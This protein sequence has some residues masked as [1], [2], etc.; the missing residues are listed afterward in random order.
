MAEIEKRLLQQALQQTGGAKLKAAQLLGISFRSFRYRLLKYGLATEDELQDAGRVVLVPACAPAGANQG[1]GR[2]LETA[3]DE[4]TAENSLFP[5]WL[6]AKDP[7][8]TV[9]EKSAVL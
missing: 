8:G 5:A 1:E 2:P 4:P 9:P 6:F 3:G 7:F